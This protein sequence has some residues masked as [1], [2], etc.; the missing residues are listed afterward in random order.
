LKVS[1]GKAKPSNEEF[2][3]LYATESLGITDVEFSWGKKLTWVLEKLL[4]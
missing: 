4:N 2:R 3:K 1:E